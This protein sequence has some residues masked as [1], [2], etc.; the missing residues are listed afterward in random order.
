MSHYRISLE[1]CNFKTNIRVFDVE[2]PSVWNAAENAVVPL[3][4]EIFEADF[5]VKVLGLFGINPFRK[6]RI[7]LRHK[8][9]P[10]SAI[11]EVEMVCLKI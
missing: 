10:I 3:F 5:K 9:M 7:E 11:I 1:K 4:G 8:R 6:N 2:A